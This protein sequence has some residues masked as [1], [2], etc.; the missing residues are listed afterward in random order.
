MVSRI[1]DEEK[2]GRGTFQDIS[3]DWKLTKNPVTDFAICTM[4]NYLANH[5]YAKFN[6]QTTID[7]LQIQTDRILKGIKAY[8]GEFGVK[9]LEKII[10]FYINSDIQQE[11]E[12]RKRTGKSKENSVMYC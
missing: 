8:L 7:I 6:E 9:Y 3:D 11:K 12:Y 5:P 1:Q 10:L 2:E 4:K